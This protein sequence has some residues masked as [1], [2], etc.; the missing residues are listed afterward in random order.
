MLLANADQAK[1]IDKCTIEKYNIPSILLMENAGMRVADEALK[2]KA[3]SFAVVIGKGNNGGDGSVA[4][5]HL[6]CSGKDVTIVLLGYDEDL[7]GDAKTAYE[8]AKNAGVKT[9]NGLTEASKECIKNSDVIIDAIFGIGISG[10]PTG[11]FKDAISYINGLKKPVISVDVPSGINADN[12]AVEGVAVMASKTVT[13]GVGRLGLRIYPAKEYAGEVCVKEISFAPEAIKEANINC[14]DV[15]YKHTEG[16]GENCHKGSVGKTL[17]AAGS[18]GMTGAA[19][20]SSLSALKSGSGVVSLCIPFFLNSVMEQKTTEI[21]TIPVDDN[22]NTMSSYATDIITSKTKSYDCLVIGCGLGV[23]DDTKELVN[24]VVKNAE[25]KIVIDADGINCLDKEVLR[26]AKHKTVITP[27]IGEMARLTGLDTGYIKSNLTEVASDFAKKYNTSVV[28]KCA[29]TVAAFPNQNVYVNTNGNRGM[30]TA[31][32]GDVLAG[33]IGSFISQ[34]IPFETAVVNGVYVHS[35]A[36]DLAAE[37]LGKKY[38]SATDIIENIA[39]VLME[40]ND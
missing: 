35:K 39:Y 23:N 12:G 25:C 6:F 13:F 26:L 5:R 17:V 30:A 27:H 28:L 9:E 32:S 10:A 34:R 29:S 14:R 4:A 7:N 11:F 21:M 2:T 33:I 22:G 3:K 40:G 24:S 19:Y 37:K 16:I 15:E 31:G 36:G 1:F 8:Y 38:M 18:L 20:M